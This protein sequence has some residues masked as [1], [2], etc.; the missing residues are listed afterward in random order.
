MR[1]L[2][3]QERDLEAAAVE[4]HAD[5]LL[6]RAR[7]SGRTSGGRPRLGQLLSD[8]LGAEPEARLPRDEAR[9]LEEGPVESEQSRHA[10]DDVLVERAEHP[11][12][13]A[14]AVAVP[15]DQ[16]GDQRVVDAD[17]LRPFGH[18]PSRRARRAR[19]ARGTRRSCRG[20]A[21]SPGARV[22]G[23]D[24]ALDRVAG[25]PHVLLAEQERLAGGDQHLLAHEVEAGHELGHRVL[26]LDA[27]V[28]LEEEVVTVAVE[29]ALDRPGPAVADGPRR[30]HRDGADPLTELR[31]DRRGRR[32]LDELLVAPLNR[33]VALAEVDDGAVSVGEHLHLDVPGVLEEP[34][35]VDRVVRRNRPRP[36]GARRP[37][38]ARPRRPSGRP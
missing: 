13:G 22:L 20:R 21:G 17:D 34:L 28:H 10:L 15:D 26:D 7:R 25:E 2:G 35:D 30:V 3:S 31:R 23:V 18:A 29:E 8:G 36:R 14:L 37:A 11:A 16:L 24:P 5:D 1:R 6:L 27:G 32:L 9:M 33:A 38:R 4:L 12:A 19:R